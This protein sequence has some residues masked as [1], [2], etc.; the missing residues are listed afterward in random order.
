MSGNYSGT[1]SEP[2]IYWAK[3]A[4]NQLVTDLS[5]NGGIGATGNEVGITTFSG[6]TAQSLGTWSS[7]ALQLAT[8][9]N[10]IGA[11]GN[12]PT[13]LGM[14]T[15]NAD[16][17]THARN[18]VGGAVKRVVIFLSDGRPNPDQG[19][20]GLPAN[21]AS[22]QRPT[23]PDITAYL[24]SADIAYSILIGTSPY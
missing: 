10:L 1:P 16:L 3:L 11:S 14:Q 13:A 24:G 2:R 20:N 5:N 21:D 17:N 22:G 18:A 19:P 12:T 23:G 9:I 7:T 6:T 8:T 4:A 15:A